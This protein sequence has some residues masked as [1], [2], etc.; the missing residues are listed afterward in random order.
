MLQEVLHPGAGG[1]QRLLPRSEPSTEAALLHL[2]PAG[3]QLGGGLLPDRGAE[4]HGDR[5]SHL[6]GAAHPGLPL[7]HA[8]CAQA[9]QEVL[10]DGHHLH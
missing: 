1:E 6:P 9:H 3:R 7:G 10:D 5:L 2:Q 8:V 4:Q